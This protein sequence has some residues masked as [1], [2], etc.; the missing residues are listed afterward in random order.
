M[1]LKAA[2][3]L[4]CAQDSEFFHVGSMSKCLNHPSL[5]FYNLK[6]KRH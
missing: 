6:N 1:Y 3:N 2:K 5:K 4:N